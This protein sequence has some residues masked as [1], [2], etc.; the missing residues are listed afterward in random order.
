MLHHFSAV[1][2]VSSYDA[3]DA[4]YSNPQILMQIIWFPQSND[5]I[6]SQELTFICDFLDSIHAIK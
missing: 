4:A 2:F 1:E 6:Y 3:F 5:E